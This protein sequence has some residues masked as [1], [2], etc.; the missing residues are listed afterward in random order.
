LKH[1][2]GKN[3]LSEYYAPYLQIAQNYGLN[4]ILET[5][6]WRANSDWGFKLGY[7]EQELQQINRDA[8]AFMRGL[9]PSMQDDAHVAVSGNIGPRGD[10][11][12]VE[13][14]MT[15]EQAKAY[16]TPQIRAF[17][18]EQADLVTALTLNYSDEAIGIVLAAQEIGVSVVIAFTVE[19]DGHLPSGESLQEAIERT[20]LATDS[21]VVHYMINCA[22]PEHFKHM[23]A[24]DGTW[25]ER[26]RGIRANA[27][28]LS[29]A[30]LDECETLDTGDKCLLVDGYNVLRE[31]LPELKVVGGCCGTD[32]S[33]LEVICES[34]FAKSTDKK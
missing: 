9:V 5:P 13:K 2:D 15:P 27:S 34:L 7:S 25:K 21:Y 1:P 6:T 17:A 33:H 19:T 26:I 16:H 24:E 29:H 8:V 30:E 12:V 32:H 4:V 22:H 20:D 10:G 11:Y 31:S 23:L 18:D 14:R 3:A 28:T